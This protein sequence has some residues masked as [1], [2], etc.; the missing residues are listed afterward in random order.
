[1]NGFP[2]KAREMCT[3]LLILI[4]L[5][6]AEIPLEQVCLCPFDIESILLPSSS[7]SCVMSE[8]R[9]ILTDRAFQVNF[10][11]DWLCKRVLEWP[12][13]K[14]KNARLTP[15]RGLKRKSEVAFSI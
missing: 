7:A 2:G 4:S 8:I 14:K 5:E 12:K 11:D 13:L 15:L 1:M 3:F 10:P 9:R 6:L